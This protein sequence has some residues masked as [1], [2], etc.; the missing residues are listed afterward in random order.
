MPFFLDKPGPKYETVSLAAHEARPGHH[1]QVSAET[2]LSPIYKQ[3]VNLDLRAFPL[4]PW[5]R[6][7]ADVFAVSN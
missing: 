6:Y 4:K 3:D 7:Y 1:T 2:L 5:E